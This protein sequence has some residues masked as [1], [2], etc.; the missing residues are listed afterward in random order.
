[1]NEKKFADQLVE[2]D[3]EQKLAWMKT[4]LQEAE[5]DIE[6]GNVDTWDAMMMRVREKNGL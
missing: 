6:E 1:M 5:K 4:K 3:M 2:S